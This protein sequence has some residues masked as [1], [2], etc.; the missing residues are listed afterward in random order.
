MPTA[1]LFARFGLFVDKE[2]LD[3][4]LCTRIVDQARSSTWRPAWIFSAGTEESRVD[5]DV[6]KT[7]HVKVPKAERGAIKERLEAL[8]PALESHFGFSL[9]EFE[10]PQL[11]R[12]REGDFFTAHLDNT[13]KEDG[14]EIARRRR[15]SMTVFLTRQ[16]EEP[17]EGSH[18]GGS[19]VFYGLMDDPRAREFGFPLKGEAGL[20]VAFRSDVL[21]EVKPVTHGERYTIVTWFF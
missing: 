18:G 13:S 3:P 4:A 6:R 15:V 16:S 2:F 20:L 5:E 10:E 8:R 9:A 1:D 21:H 14:A 19:L 7:L 12:Y 17:A 11:L